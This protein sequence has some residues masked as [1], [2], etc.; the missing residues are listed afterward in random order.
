M[1]DITVLVELL[2]KELNDIIPLECVAFDLRTNTGTV[3]PMLDKDLKKK[4]KRQ[5]DVTIN[6]VVTTT[7]NNVTPLLGLDNYN[8][9]ASLSVAVPTFSQVTDKLDGKELVNIVYETFVKYITVNNGISF[10]AEFVDINTGEVEEYGVIPIFEM[11]TVTAQETIPS[12]GIGQTISMFIEYQIIKKAVFSADVQYFIDG[13]QLV[14][15]NAV[16]T[17]TVVADTDN[18]E[19]EEQLRNVITSNGVMFSLTMPYLDTPVMQNLVRQTFAPNITKKYTLKY[20][21]GVAFTAEQPFEDT[22]VM[23]LGKVETSVGKIAGIT[24]EFTLAY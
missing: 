13:E 20:I 17:S 8:V 23:Q 5:C 10:P 3:K 4:I 9:L 6:G 7:P 15:L 14:V 21:D 24:A 19:N 1:V 16:T 12:L 18:T 22:V 11:P 2:E